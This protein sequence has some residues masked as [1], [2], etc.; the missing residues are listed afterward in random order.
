MPLASLAAVPRRL[1][2]AD[3]TSE[4]RA[5]FAGGPR[6]VS[7]PSGHSR[8]RRTGRLVMMNAAQAK[9]TNCRRLAGFGR[10]AELRRFKVVSAACLR[11]RYAAFGDQR[12]EKAGL[13]LSAV[14]QPKVRPRR[15]IWTEADC[16]TAAP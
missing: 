1:A 8:Q 14:C 3:A 12:K 6:A 9:S 13:D 11:K 16:V 5:A 7:E 10:R 15:I 2:A 4:E